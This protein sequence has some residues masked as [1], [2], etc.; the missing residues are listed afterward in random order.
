MKVNKKCNLRLKI[1]FRFLELMEK[2]RKKVKYKVKKSLI[3]N[4][5][6]QIKQSFLGLNSR[7]MNRYKTLFQTLNKVVKGVF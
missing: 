2:E 4:L 6:F 3:S 1:K 7:K 5:S